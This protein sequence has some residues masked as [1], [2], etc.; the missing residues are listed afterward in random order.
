ME[1]ETILSEGREGRKVEAKSIN[2]DRDRDRD[3]EVGKGT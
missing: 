1:Y 3:H 2:R